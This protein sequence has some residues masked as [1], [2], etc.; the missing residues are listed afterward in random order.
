MRLSTFV[1]VRIKL[2]GRFSRRG[3]ELIHRETAKFA[4]ELIPF[5][6]MMRLLETFQ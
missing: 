4:L 2:D 3:I 5:C 6:D 1:P